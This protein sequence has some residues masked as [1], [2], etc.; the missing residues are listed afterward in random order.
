[1]PR[2]GSYPHPVLGNA[3]DV[4]TLFEV[5]L[6]H[7]APS[8]DDIRITCQVRMTDPDVQKLLDNG[9]A[10]LSFRWTCSPT[11]SSGEL[12]PARVARH[13]D[14]EAYE[15][16]LDQQ[17]VR[18]KVRVDVQIIATEEI[19]HYRLSN[20]HEDYGD[21]TFHILPGD[22]L[23]YAGPFEFSPDKLYD[24]LDPPVGSLYTFVGGG[25]GR[26]V[27]V[28]FDDDEHILVVFDPDLLAGLAAMSSRVDLQIGLVVLPALMQTITFVK[29]N[30]DPDGEDLT[31]RDWYEPICRLVSSNGGFEVQ[32]FEVAQKILGNPLDNSLRHA[33]EVEEDDE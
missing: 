8:V 26:Q 20:Q 25:R 19:D 28:R 9:S 10:R 7:Y 27:T 29:E 5:F 2:R 22:V 11:I 23:A 14:S 21:A 30:S 13:A 31:G 32:A 24:P 1:M 16:W 4:S 12:T 6:F 33:F 17:D 3:D 18:G 15:G